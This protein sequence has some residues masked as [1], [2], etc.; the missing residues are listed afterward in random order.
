MMVN[1]AVPGMSL[2]HSFILACLLGLFFDK[3]AP[4]IIPASSLYLSHRF[5]I[6][7]TIAS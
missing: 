5:H 2:A 4:S 3:A 6:H 7:Y 1:T